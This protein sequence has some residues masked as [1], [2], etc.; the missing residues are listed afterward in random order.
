MSQVISKLIFV[1]V[2]TNTIKLNLGI[3]VSKVLLLKLCVIYIGY[4]FDRLDLEEIYFGSIYNDG[5]ACP[6]Q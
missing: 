4:N 2:K 5:Q 6:T 1:I 3:S